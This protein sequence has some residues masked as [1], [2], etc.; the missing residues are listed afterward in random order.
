MK[1]KI[2]ESRVR[3]GFKFYYSKGKSFLENFPNVVLIVR[4]LWS[5]NK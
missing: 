1:S 3:E 4:I 5:L 2:F